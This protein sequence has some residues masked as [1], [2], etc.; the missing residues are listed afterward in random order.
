MTLDEL[1]IE[2]GL[3]MFLCRMTYAGT[4]VYV[5]CTVVDVNQHIGAIKVL[6]PFNK[7]EFKSEWFPLARLSWKDLTPPK[8]TK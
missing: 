3:N 8:P 6:Y 4:K 7:T 5:A 1:P 2:I